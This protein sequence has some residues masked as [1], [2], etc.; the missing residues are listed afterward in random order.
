MHIF[1]WHIMPVVISTAIGALVGTLVVE[2][3]LRL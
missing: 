2:R 1:L 3:M